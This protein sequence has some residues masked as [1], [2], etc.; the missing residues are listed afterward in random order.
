MMA[1]VWTLTGKEELGGDDRLGFTSTTLTGGKSAGVHLV[2]LKCNDLRISVLP[3]RGMNILDVRSADGNIYFG[4]DSP[5]PDPVHPMWVPISEPS[6]LGWLDG[7]NEMLVRCGLESNGAP[8]HNEQG[9]LEYPLHGR[10]ANLPASS[11]EVELDEKNGTIRLTGKVEETRFHIRRSCLT[12]TITCNLANPDEVT[13]VDE[14]QNLSNRPSDFQLLYHLNIGSPV[15]EAGAQFVAPYSLVCPRNDHA[16][17]GMS[18]WQNFPDASSDYQEQVYFMRLAGN[19]ENRTKALLHNA[20]K[21]KGFSVGYRVDQLP[22]FSL[23]KNT[24]GHGDGFVTGLEPAVNYPN[25]RKFEA[26]HGR[27]IPL[28]P[29]ETKQFELS[30]GF[31]Q[32]GESVNSVLNEIAGLTADSPEVHNQPLDEL[33]EP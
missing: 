10:I 32:S 33:C 20:A 8:Q 3:T 11:V 18:D 17:T 24:V 29:K 27:V 28:A 7:F 30:L 6:G 21:D 13:I 16:A 15:L 23:W 4:W 12:T 19:A 26:E 25:R 1:K 31:H 9:Q 22:C 2:V 14:V 5:I